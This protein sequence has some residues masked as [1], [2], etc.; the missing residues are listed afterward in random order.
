MRK[1]KPLII[2]VELW[3]AVHA[4]G[5]ETVPQYMHAGFNFFRVQFRRVHVMVY[6][7]CQQRAVEVNQPVPPR[8]T[9]NSVV[10]T[11]S[12][13]GREVAACV[14]TLPLDML[15]RAELAWLGN[16]PGRRCHMHI[17]VE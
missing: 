11:C 2:Q 9:G 16:R 6:V 14:L 1:R 4:Q 8:Y 5:R 7:T 3:E 17:G 13:G 12:G 15:E 10:Q